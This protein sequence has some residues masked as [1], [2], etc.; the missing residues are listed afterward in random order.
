[1]IMPRLLDDVF[2]KLPLERHELGRESEHANHDVAMLVGLYFFRGL[3][4][5]FIVFKAVKELL[6]L[7]R[8]VVILRRGGNIPSANVW[9]KAACVVLFLAMWPY[10][11]DVMRETRDIFLW[12][13]A[14]AEVTALAGYY[15]EFF[16]GCG[17]CEEP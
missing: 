13:A 4:L 14:A 16:R 3:P 2:L 9:G 11:V 15:M 10:V 6:L 1:M 12:V 8:G 5:N 17:R 7:P